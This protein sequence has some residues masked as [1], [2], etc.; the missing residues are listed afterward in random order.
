MIRDEGIDEK[1]FFQRMDIFTR[2]HSSFGYE[3]H[4]SLPVINTNAH[5]FYGT[6]IR[7]CQK[8]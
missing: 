3:V 7:N 2:L 1:F 6:G 5:P 4:S 8:I